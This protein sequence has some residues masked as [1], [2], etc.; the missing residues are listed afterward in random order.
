MV[1]PLSDFKYVEKITFCVASIVEARQCPLV[2]F[3][4]KLMKNSGPKKS[5]LTQFRI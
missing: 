3:F 1:P 2:D 4:L 5:F